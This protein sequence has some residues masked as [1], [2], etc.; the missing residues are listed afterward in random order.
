[1]KKTEK[2]K[3]R[4][5]AFASTLVFF[6]I[7]AFSGWIILSF[8]KAN[9]GM[10]GGRMLAWFL[11]LLGA[12]YAGLILEIAAH[13]AGHLIFGLMSGYRFSSYRLFSFMWMKENERVV[14]RRFSIAGT[15]GQCLMSP[16][17]PDE[18]GHIPF[19][20]YNLGG[21]IVNLVTAVVFLA[22]AIL[23]PNHSV[24]AVLFRMLV[25]IAAGF[26][27]INGFPLRIGAVD[28]DGTNTLVML[29]EPASVISFWRMMKINERTGRGE[30]LRDMPEEWFGEPDEKLFENPIA[31]SQAVFWL[32]RILDE[33]RYADMARE[34][35]AFL[36]RDSALNGIYRNLLICDLVTCL[37][38]TER[39]GEVSV[40]LTPEAV[41]FMKTMQR[42]PSVLRCGIALALLRDGDMGGAEKLQTQFETVARTYP[43]PA[44]IDAEREILA[45][46]KNKQSEKADIQT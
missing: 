44:E 15:G 1:M 14:F 29:R 17:D 13:E 33:G 25:V 23:L 39:P 36:K 12:M 27:L 41:R 20:L 40:R 3:G 24:F 26:A 45:V 7:G 10:S 43:Y 9:A 5:G 11:V 32:N 31:C 38:I 28:N 4:A 16:P 46:I 8:L 2:T 18:N 34:A 6:L 35:E 21:V 30:R 42:S 22:P 19:V 37:L